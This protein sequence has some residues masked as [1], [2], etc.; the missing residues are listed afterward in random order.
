MRV[1]LLGISGP[2]TGR[3]FNLRGG[4]V[5]RIGRTDWADFSFP[6][7]SSLADIHFAI[8]CGINSVVVESLSDAH[9]TLVNDQA[10][11]KLRV[12]NDDVIAAGNCRFQFAIDE[13]VGSYDAVAATAAATSIVETQENANEALEIAEYIG[14]SPEAIDLAKTCP[15]ARKF[16]DV[17][18]DEDK[19]KDAIRWYAHTMPK[20]K[21]VLWA[22][23]CTEELMKSEPNT[24]QINAYE[25]AKAWANDPTEDNRNASLQ[26]AKQS[27]YEG[28]GGVLAAAAGWSGGTL[29]PANLPDIPPDDRLTARCVSTA[30]S[31]ASCIG[32]PKETPTRLKA[33]LDIVRPVRSP[34]SPS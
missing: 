25:S 28:L 10:V 15:S 34:Q 33:F 14:L 31:M 32:P 23:R 8:H 13:G 5:A 12:R 4:Q 29:G 3:R 24:V 2:A 1:A 22:I 7:D 26:L 30:L 9:E 16:G 11:S 19:I 17:L 20:P 27:E 18:A 21:A 6:D